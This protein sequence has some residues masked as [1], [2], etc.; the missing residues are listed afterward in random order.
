MSTGVKAPAPA[1]GSHP[2]ATELAAGRIDLDSAMNALVDS[3]ADG[4]LN[5]TVAAA[6]REQL[7]ALL[8]SALA[9]DPSLQALM[10]DLERSLES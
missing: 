3:V 9:G 10:R 6:E 2:I 5:P 7:V 1:D 4:A 8:R